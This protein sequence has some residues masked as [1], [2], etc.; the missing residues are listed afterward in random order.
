MFDINAFILQLLM[1]ANA[2]TAAGYSY[3]PS[4]P[5]NADSFTPPTVERPAKMRLRIGREL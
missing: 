1:M 4:K 2:Y 5:L 3:D